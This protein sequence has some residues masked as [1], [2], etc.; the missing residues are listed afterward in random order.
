MIKLFS[1]KFIAG[2]FALAVVL[3][4]ATYA[5]TADFFIIHTKTKR[6]R[7]C[8]AFFNPQKYKT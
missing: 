6:H 4:T 2:S 1:S 5:A 3:P 7:H 8:N